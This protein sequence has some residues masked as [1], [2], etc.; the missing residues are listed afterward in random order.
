MVEESG[1]ASISRPLSAFAL[2][3]RPTVS[4][5]EI[6]GLLRRTGFGDLSLPRHLLLRAEEEVKYGAF[7]EREAREVS[8][9]AA[10]ERR[11]LPENIDYTDV[12]GLRTE[13]RQKLHSHRPRT[14]GEAGRLA[15]VTPADVAALLIH[16]TRL[17]A[18]TR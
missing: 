5:D 17:E 7:I 6:A 13:A 16:A 12:T 2:L 3:R 10:L 14:F 15:G 8:R 11:P 4:I 9:R 18:A 1:L